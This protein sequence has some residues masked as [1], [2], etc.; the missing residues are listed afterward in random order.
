QQH[1]LA[2]T[3][4]DVELRDGFPDDPFELPQCDAIEQGETFQRTS[5]ER[6]RT[7]RCRLAG[8]LAERDDL[9]GHIAR[10]NETSISGIDERN[11]RL[12]FGGEL[13]ERR[14]IEF[15]AV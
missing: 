7:F 11:E 9:R 15:L 12:R 14:V 10:T 13:C 5:D 6:P 2:A 1:V 3:A 4:D 8:F